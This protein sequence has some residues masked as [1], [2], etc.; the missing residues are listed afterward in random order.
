MAAGAYTLYNRS[1]RPQ[2]CPRRI[3]ILADGNLTVL[4]DASEVD[5]PPGAVTA[6]MVFD[7]DYSAVTCS[8]AIYVQW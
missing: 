2:V 1:G 5:S 7:G 8:A 4:K 6:G 3:T